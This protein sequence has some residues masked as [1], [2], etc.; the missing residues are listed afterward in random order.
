MVDKGEMRVGGFMA[1][2]WKLLVKF[3]PHIKFHRRM[4]CNISKFSEKFTDCGNPWWTSWKCMW[5]VL[6]P[7]KWNILVKFYPHIKFHRRML[8][9]NI[10]K[11]SEN[12][13]DYENLRLTSGKCTWGLLAPKVKI[14]VKF[15]PHIKFHRTMLCN[16]SKILERFTHY[17]IP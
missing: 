1:P 12:F 10:S 2:K 14:L 3:H 11:F 17:E 15:Q 9:C 6:W 8:L 4:L 7:T 16:M 5:G 13:P